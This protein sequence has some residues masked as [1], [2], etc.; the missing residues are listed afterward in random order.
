MDIKE[1]GE[2][3]QKAVKITY[4]QI[5]VGDYI[6]L[7]DGR[8]C[9][10]HGAIVEI[11]EH[12]VIS[13]QGIIVACKETETHTYLLKKAKTPLPTEIGSYIRITDTRPQQ[14]LIEGVVLRLKEGHDKTVRPVWHAGTDTRGYYAKFFEEQDI[15][16]EQVWLSTKE[17]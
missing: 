3:L 2:L 8:G 6:Y 16:W 5:K 14:Y 1:L 17:S 11:N 10:R 13:D 15:E 7:D 4:N 9:P 12:G